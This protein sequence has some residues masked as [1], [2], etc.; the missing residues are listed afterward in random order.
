MVKESSRDPKILQEIHNDWSSR[1]FYSVAICKLAKDHEEVFQMASSN[2]GFQFTFSLDLDFIDWETMNIPVEALLFW[3][4]ANSFSKLLDMIE[5]WMNNKQMNDHS[6]LAFIDKLIEMRKIQEKLKAYENIT[7][8]RIE[9]SE[10]FLTFFKRMSLDRQKQQL[11]EEFKED[12]TFHSPWIEEMFKRRL[13]EFGVF[14]QVPGRLMRKKENLL[15]LYNALKCGCDFDYDVLI[16]IIMFQNILTDALK[17]F[18][19]EK[20]IMI[21]RAGMNLANTIILENYLE[22]RNKIPEFRKLIKF[23]T[24]SIEPATEKCFC[25]NKKTFCNSQRRD[26]V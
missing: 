17:N 13:E 12:F 23:K 14:E 7:P 6:E 16:N 5:P 18:N 25:S 11:L 26:N 8:R 24:T 19:Q 21:L 1:D 10:S 4:D 22:Q 9:R 20:M 3:R 2:P 15:F